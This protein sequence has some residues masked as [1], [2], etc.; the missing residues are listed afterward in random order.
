MTKKNVTAIHQTKNVRY[1]HVSQRINSILRKNE[2][3]EIPTLARVKF[4]MELAVK[5]FD[6]VVRR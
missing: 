2:I 1:I 3:I 5:L 6:R 4:G